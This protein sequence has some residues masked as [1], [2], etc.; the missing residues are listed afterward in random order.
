MCAAAKHSAQ[1]LAGAQLM[2]QRQPREAIRGIEQQL[3]GNTKSIEKTLDR[4]RNG[5]IWS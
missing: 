2:L 1:L 3:H 5:C 4:Q